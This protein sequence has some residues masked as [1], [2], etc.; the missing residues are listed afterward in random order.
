MC[1]RYALSRDR[2]DLVDLFDVD[3]EFATS[4]AG[5]DWNMAPTKQAPVVVARRPP[6]RPDAAP[7]V[8]LRD[9]TWGLV[10]SWSKDSSIGQKMIN[11]RAETVDTKPAHRNAFAKRRGLAPADGF[12][13]WRP[14]DQIG[15][16]GKPVKQP[17]FLH[18]NDGGVLA[19]AAIYEF[20]RNPNKDPDDEDAWLVSYSVITTTSTDD[21][22]RVH[23]RMP[24]TVPADYWADWLDPDTNPGQAKT[25]MQPP[26][27]G[28]LDMYPVSR[29]VNNVAHNGPDLVEPL[30]NDSEDTPTG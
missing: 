21:V 11:A 27:L 6:G 20:W 22:G 19:L 24:V 14:S 7:A 15:T 26:P 16:S 5:A 18:P 23:D 9:L 30:P 17:Y 1:G 25:I 28:S 10:P 29:Q 4:Q 12:F 8:Q 2:D 13:E 3:P